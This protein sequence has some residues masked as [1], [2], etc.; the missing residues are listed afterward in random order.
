MGDKLKTIVF[1][2]SVEQDRRL[3][4]LAK[5]L[6]LTKRRAFEKAIELYLLVAGK[7]HKEQND[8]E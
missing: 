8:A 4:A 2:L 3:A 5:E 6:G 7:E 1:N